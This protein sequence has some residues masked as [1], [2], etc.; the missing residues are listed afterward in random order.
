MVLNCDR[1]LEGASTPFLADVM[2]GLHGSNI[3]QHL[4]WQY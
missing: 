1:E 4:L 3:C 2:K